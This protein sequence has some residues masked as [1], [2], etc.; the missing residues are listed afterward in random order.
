MK[1]YRAVIAFFP[2]ALFL[3]LADRVLYG[4]FDRLLLKST[5]RDI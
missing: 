4:I 1:S 2:I 3:L 5:R